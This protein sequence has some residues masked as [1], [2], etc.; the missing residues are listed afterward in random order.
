MLKNRRLLQRR[1]TPN[2]LIHA[3]Q[4]GARIAVRRCLIAGIDEDSIRKNVT[5]QFRKI[6]AHEDHNDYERETL[7]ANVQ[8]SIES[9]LDH[10]RTHEEIPR[11]E[12]L[13][14][15]SDD[16]ENR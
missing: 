9:V 16:S 6:F 4:L 10:G 5:S 15:W 14:V 11:A 1:G 3:A 7:M 13:H 12:A 2:D 8:R